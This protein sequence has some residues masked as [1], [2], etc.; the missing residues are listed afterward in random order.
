MLHISR[1]AALQEGSVLLQYLIM[2]H[3]TGEQCTSAGPAPGHRW[4]DPRLLISILI[5]H[6]SRR[7]RKCVITNK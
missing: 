3:M 6:L 1:C 2:S 7:K 5:E 4:M